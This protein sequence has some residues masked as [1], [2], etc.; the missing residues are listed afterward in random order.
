MFIHFPMHIPKLRINPF[1]QW[2]KGDTNIYGPSWTPTCI[3]TIWTYFSYYSLC[4]TFLISS[5]K[6]LSLPT[7]STTIWQTFHIITACMSSP[8]CILLFAL[9]SPVICKDFFSLVYMYKSSRYFPVFDIDLGPMF[10]QS[11]SLWSHETSSTAALQAFGLYCQQLPGLTT[12]SIHYY[13]HSHYFR[14]IFIFIALRILP[15][16]LS[17]HPVPLDPLAPKLMMWLLSS[18][19]I[20]MT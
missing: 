19:K 9:H 13:L 20:P 17:L 1:F 6:I 12:K 5:Q 14:T 11:T 15:P 8:P 16:T 18:A 7:S 3:C 2:Y 4:F 10:P